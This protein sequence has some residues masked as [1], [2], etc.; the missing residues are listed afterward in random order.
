MI[1]ILHSLW[2]ILSRNEKVFI[3][4]LLLMMLISS[5]LEIIGI[6]LVLP[7]VALLTKPELIDENAYLNHIFNF[8]DSPSHSSFIITLSIVLISL[9]LLKNAFLAFQYYIQSRFIMRKGAMLANTLFSNYLYSTYRN[10]LK[11]NSGYLLGNIGL[12]D[13]LAAYMLL[14]LMALGTELIVVVAIFAMLLYLY[15]IVTIG[16]IAAVSL[17]SI[18]IYF[19]LRNLNYRLGKTFKEE[20]LEM[21]KFALQGLNSFKESKIKGKEEYFLG[22]Y[23]HHRDIFN[24]IHSMIIFLRILPRCLV[25]SLAVSMGLVVL[26]ILVVN[27]QS[28]KEIILTVSLFAMAAVRLMPSLTRIQNSLSIIR[29]YTNSF[30]ALFNDITESET[31]SLPK[32]EVELQFK[33][34]VEIN[35]VSFSYENDDAYVL[36]NFSLVIPKNQSIALVG[37]TGCGKTTLID[38]ILGLLHPESGSVKVDD[39]DINRNLSSWRRM[40][41]YVPQSVFLL[42]DTIRAN[43]AFGEHEEQIDDSRVIECLKLAQ[44]YD[45]VDSLPEGVFHIIGEDGAR[46][47]GGQRQRICIA[48]ALYGKP[49]LLILDEATSALDNETEKAFIDALNS[50]K[51]QLTIIMIAH[52]LSSVKQCDVIIDLSR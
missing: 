29:Q 23:K 10:H 41:G 52:R 46:L 6:S 48:R 27:G 37:L 21:N 43:V 31:E 45:F 34:T 11:R 7:I 3:G 24:K 5:I 12:A 15:P 36:K 25:E 38:V 18:I 35:Q 40:I 4:V 19:P 49:D 14:P 17:I 30:H 50:L 26:I 8:F 28:D 16:M 32:Q 1:E 13:L 39:V 33:K 47:S 44:V 42:D 22:E 51:G 9:Y 20:V 2:T